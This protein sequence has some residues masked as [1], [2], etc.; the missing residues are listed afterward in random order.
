MKF[1]SKDNIHPNEKL[2][3]LMRLEDAVEAIFATDHR[4]VGSNLFE[5]VVR[6]VHEL[7]GADVVI[8]GEFLVDSDL[9]RTLGFWDEGAVR[10]NFSYALEDTPCK[11][12]IVE[13]G[14]SFASGAW[15]MFPDDSELVSRGIEAYVGIPFYFKGMEPRG[16][17]LAMFKTA[18]DDCKVVSS[19]L[20]IYGVRVALEL[21]HITNRRLL[22][23]QNDNLHRLFEQLSVKN[24]ELDRYVK[25]VEDAKAM[26]EESNQLKTAFLANLS[27]EVR[28]P[29]NV[30]LGFAELLK[31][32]VLS[33]EERVEYIDIINQ[34]G[35][36]LLKIMDNLIDI[37]KFQSR[38]VLESPKALPLNDLLDR[39]YLQYS[40]Y[41]RMVQKSLR[42]RI[43]KALPDGSD[44]IMAD[45]EGVSKVLNQLLDNAVKFTF[46][47]E[48]TFGYRLEGDAVCFYVIDTGIGVP[49]GMDDK[50]FEMFR[51]VDLRQSRDFGGNGL[52]LA[53]ARKFTELMGGT[54]WL[55]RSMDSVTCFCFKI[56]WVKAER[57]L[58]GEKGTMN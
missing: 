25:E 7:L 54:I 22:E 31:S 42:L 13:R 6:S 48:I 46:E 24:H 38:T 53:I 14:C 51:Q 34:N 19:L 30:M 27:H 47:G 57:K 21:E 40:D 45:N 33:Q 1:F 18:I 17:I 28:T 15:R 8:V 52:G 43:D 37:S 55:D 3:R 2:Q 5:S 44:V 16:I 41:L 36:Q 35:M 50:I 9:I 20:K 49:E 11:Q 29:M 56:P 10:E 58:T 4:Y 39:F 26:A 23:Q 32:D 12:A